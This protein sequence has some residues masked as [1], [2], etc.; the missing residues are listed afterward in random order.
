MTE[1]NPS[2]PH[3][4]QPKATGK[5]P[6]PP[7]GPKVFD[8]NAGGGGWGAYK[9]FLGDKG[10]KKFQNQLCQG[11]AQQIQKNKQKEEKRKEMMKKS[12]EGKN[13]YD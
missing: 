3:P 10:F 1:V 11:I 9:A 4:K 7:G 12:F 6:S 2:A 13:I 8:P 5:T